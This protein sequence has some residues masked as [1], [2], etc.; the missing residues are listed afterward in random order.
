MGKQLA[1][2][3][4]HD[5][6]VHGVA[7]SSDGSTLATASADDT[8]KLWDTGTYQQRATFRHP[9]YGGLTPSGF[10]C[11]AFAPGGQV[12]AVGRQDGV[13]T[14]YRADTGKE[15]LTML[16]H[17]GPVLSVAF[18]P[19]GRTI[20]SAGQDGAVLVRQ[21]SH[22]PGWSPAGFEG[23]LDLLVAP[24]QATL[25]A[26]SPGNRLGRLHLW[27]VAA[28][29]ER[30]A[31][32]WLASVR[33]IDGVTVS[34]DGKTAVVLLFQGS[35]LLWNL[36]MGDG[37]PLKQQRRF[38]GPW[39][40]APD[41]KTVAMSWY[42]PGPRGS[43]LWDWAREEDRV[44]FASKEVFHAKAFTPDGKT[45]L[46]VA[47]AGNLV[48]RW[49]VATGKE[50]ATLKV[51]NTFTL[52]SGRECLPAPDAGTLLVLNDKGLRLWDAAA[53]RELAKLELPT[54]RPGT[55]GYSPDSK[56]VVVAVGD[57]AFLFDASGRATHRLNGGHSGDVRGYAFSPDSKQV[58]TWGADG[59]VVVWEVGTGKP[60]HS[61]PLKGPSEQVVFTPDGRHLL[62]SNSNGTIYILRLTPAPAKK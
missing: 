51:S 22:V 8:V 56:T 53:D 42:T 44:V 2:L 3:T 5:G 1:T 13:V 4:G 25:V 16:G 20:A 35:V 27:D 34:P 45:L 43:A 57:T 55:Y 7:W 46:S 39:V 29:K 10:L 61:W 23:G 52:N 19:D 54:D 62:I 49:D 15:W 38:A 24:E 17:K 12:L 11:V 30:P 50:L 9:I 26:W 37:L 31:P 47:G 60:L 6:S 21:L 59:R 32:P 28:G 41:S 33:A 18:A 58:A 48:Q 40:F 36:A 14:L